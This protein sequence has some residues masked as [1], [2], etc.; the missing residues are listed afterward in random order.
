[1]DAVKY[2]KEKSRMGNG[3]KAYEVCEICPLSENENGRDL[4]CNDF[5]LDYPEEAVEI[6]AKWAAEHPVKTRQSEFLMMFPNALINDG[7]LRIHPCDMDKEYI[8][9]DSEKC[10]AYAP[11]K[12]AYGCGECC[13][14]YWLAEV[15]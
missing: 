15:E 3:C 13:R 1:M 5:E 6:V 10:R 14:D 7:V 2:L 9:Q 4:E 12:L 11:Q 8:E